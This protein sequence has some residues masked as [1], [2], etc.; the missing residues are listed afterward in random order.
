MGR[1][2]PKF[3]TGF[4]AIYV[5]QSFVDIGGYTFSTLMI[6]LPRTGVLPKGFVSAPWSIITLS[7]NGYCL[8]FQLTA[9]AFIAYNRYTALNNPS[10]HRW[11][12]KGRRLQKIVILLLILPLPGVG[13][14]PFSRIEVVESGQ[15]YALLWFPQWTYA[16][17][18]LVLI[19]Y[20]VA[21]CAISSTLKIATLVAYR[22]M[23]A[24]TKKEVRDDFKLLLYAMFQFVGQ[25]LLTTYS[26]LIIYA[27]FTEDTDLITVTQASFSY[28][29]DILSLSGP[30]CLF[31][32]RYYT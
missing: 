20:G 5:F 17:N 4:F 3:T 30:V 14:K 31:A 9:H 1:R 29:V 27:T 8:C 2:N 18:S 10:Q 21:S 12:W 25:S 26:L 13:F 16:Y 32:T 7:L 24:R 6:R 28:I 11:L 19:V 15:G 22:R 23:S